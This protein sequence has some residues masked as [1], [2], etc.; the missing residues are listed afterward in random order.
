MTNFIAEA[1]SYIVALILTLL[2]VPLLVI[3]GI[4]CSIAGKGYLFD[5]EEDYGMSS[6]QP[7]KPKR[8]KKRKS[9]NAKA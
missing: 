5:E 1:S 6:Y 7:E 9:K 2:F 4:V 8:K 3:A